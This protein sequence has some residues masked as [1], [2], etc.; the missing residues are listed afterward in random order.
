MKEQLISFKTAKLAK[1]KGF[2]LPSHSYYFED[3]EFEKFEINDTY[4]YYGDEYSVEM[5]EFYN[6]W[7]DDWKTDKEGNRCFGCDKNPEY[8]E[9]YSAPTQ[10]FLQRWLRE[11]YG[12]QID[13]KSVLTKNGWKYRIR[14]RTEHIGLKKGK[15]IFKYEFPDNPYFD[16]YEEALEKGLYKSLELI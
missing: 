7:N 5:S 2:N 11:E 12:V 4:G 14:I 16:N 15:Q 1:E 9:T 3:G 8:L 6:N 13:I 10:A